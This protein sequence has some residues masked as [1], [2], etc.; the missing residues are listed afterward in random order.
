VKFR[1]RL[2]GQNLYPGRGEHWWKGITAD[3]MASL[4]RRI[5]ELGFD[6]LSLGEHVVMHEELLDSM[7]PR[8][9]HTLSLMSYVACAT[10]RIR[11]AAL[12]VVPYHNPLVLAKALATIDYL[13]T[14]RL[15]ALCGVGYMQWEYEV[16]RIP[17]FEERGAVMDEYLDAMLEL[18]TSEK[19]RFAGRYT[20]F[21]RIVFDPK[22][23]QKP[24][25]PVWVAGNSPAAARRAA[26][27]GG[28]W[29]PSAISRARLSELLAEIDAR[30][31]SGRRPDAF[32]VYMNLF[33]GEIEWSRLETRRVPRIDTSR[34]AV[35]A[36]LHA[37]SE[38]GVTVTDGDALAGGTV[39]GPEVAGQVQSR[40]EYLERLQWFAEEIVPAA[41]E[42]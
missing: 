18:W 30:F 40:E 28:G 8:Y 26:R 24:H 42:L 1:V 12:V 6:Y 32:D 7:G 5:D 16:L 35:I 41:R 15:V 29:M 31:Q 11:I 23:V 21:D 22:P 27:M 38:L 19:P 36:E 2:P 25:P 4:A 9:L 10:E 34:D 3:E 17:P 13:S 14:G 33:E 20:R 39:F 37:L